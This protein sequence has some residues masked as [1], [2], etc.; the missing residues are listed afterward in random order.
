MDFFKIA[1][2]SEEM[3]PTLYRTSMLQRFPSFLRDQWVTHF[4]QDFTNFNTKVLKFGRF[5]FLDFL[6]KSKGI[7]DSRMSRELSRDL[8]SVDFLKKSTVDL[9]LQNLKI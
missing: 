5:G 8:M 4:G 3:K 9:K 1:S 6:R 2:I 7:Q